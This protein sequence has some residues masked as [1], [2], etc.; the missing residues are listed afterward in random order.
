MEPDEQHE[1][2]ADALMFGDAVLTCPN[3]HSWATVYKPEGLGTGH[4]E[5]AECPQ[6]GELGEE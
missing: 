4:F 1:D 2:F 3:G 6:C 5:Q